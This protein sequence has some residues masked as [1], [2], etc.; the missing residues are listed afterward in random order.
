MGYDYINGQPWSSTRALQGT[1]RSGLGVLFNST[2]GEEA[3]WLRFNNPGSIGYAV[4]P[5]NVDGQPIPARVYPE[6]KKML[7]MKNPAVADAGPEE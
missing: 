2:A 6:F 4:T 3:K 7:C 5:T 1:A